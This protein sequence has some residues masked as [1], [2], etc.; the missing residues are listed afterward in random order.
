MLAANSPEQLAIY[1]N[2]IPMKRMGRPDE[3][4]QVVLF[5]ASD[6]SS[7]VTGAEIAVDGGF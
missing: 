5:L 6:L 3:V 4:A 1:K 7:Y 2:M